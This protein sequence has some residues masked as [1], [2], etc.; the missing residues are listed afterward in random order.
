[1]GFI[2]N[3]PVI[4]KESKTLIF[5]RESV[6]DIVFDGR[7]ITFDARQEIVLRCGEGSVKLRK[8]GTIIIKGINLVSRARAA[9]KIKGAAVK[10]N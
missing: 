5:D 7:R 10:I 6:E 8:D 3:Q 9:N 2:Q 4:K 1:V